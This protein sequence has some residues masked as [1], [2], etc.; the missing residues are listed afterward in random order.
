[1][2]RKRKSKVTRI[3]AMIL[4]I[5]LVTYNIPASAIVQVFAQGEDETAVQQTDVAAGQNQEVEAGQTPE[6]PGNPQTEQPAPAPNVTVNQTG[7]GHVEINGAEYSAPIWISEGTTVPTVITPGEGYEIQ[8]VTI[9]GET[10]EVAD[11]TRFEDDIQI[12]SNT[13]IEVS[14]VL[15]SH[16]IQFNDF[17]NGTVTNDADQQPV[18]ANGEISVQ[19]GTEHSFTATPDTGYHIESIKVGTES[20]DLPTDVKKE[21]NSYQFTVPMVTKNVDVEVKFA[22]NTYT[23]TFIAGENGTVDS[24]ASSGGTVQVDY[25]KQ[26]SF[27]AIPEQNYHVESVKVGKDFIPIPEDVKKETTNFPYEIKNITSNIE[28]RVTFSINTH[29]VT[30]TVKGGNGSVRLDK[31]SVEHDGK[32]TVTIFPD[33]SYRVSEVKVTDA[34]GERSV[35]LESA[36]FISNDNETFTYITDN[37]T[38]DTRIEVSFEAMPAAQPWDKFV[39]IDPNA[40]TLIQKERTDGSNFDNILIYSRDAKLTVKPID[41]YNRVSFSRIFGW[42]QEYTLRESTAISDIRVKTK[43]NFYQKN[44][45]WI[46]LPDRLFLIIDTKNPEVKDIKL[47]DDNNQDGIQVGNKVW[48]K[49]AVTVSGTIDNVK[50]DEKTGIEYSTDI[51][52]VY[53]SKGGYSETDRQ[54]AAFDPKTKEFTF[55]TPDEAYHG[56]YTVWAVDK[57]GN[58]S[59]VEKINI[60]IDKAEPALDGDATNKAVLLSAQSKNSSFAA[61]V[62]NFLTFGTFF[63]EDIEVTVNAVDEASGI[64]SIT[65]QKDKENLPE[66]ESDS[67]RPTGLK[68]VN[69]FTLD[70]GFDGK[71]TAV[72][73][74]N[75]GHQYKVL[76]TNQNSNMMA[77]NGEVMIETEPPTANISVNPAGDVTE[78]VDQ[79]G[80][81]FY[82]GDAKFNVTAQ[83]KKSGIHSVKIEANGKTFKDEK[84]F[85]NK[86]EKETSEL[87]YPFTTG[88]LKDAGIT[89]DNEE[90]SY[91]VSAVVKDNAGNINSSSIDKKIFIDTE[92]PHLT[93]GKEAVNIEYQYDET[94]AKALNFLTFGTF[95]NKQIAIKVNASDNE[96]GSGIKDIYVKATDD[97]QEVQKLK[98]ESDSSNLAT[99]TLDDVHFK[100]TLDVVVTDN[101]NNQAT[102]EVSGANSNILSEK[103]REIMIEQNAP[104]AGITV[105]HDADVSSVTKD[106]KEFYSNDVTFGIHVGDPDS[107]V[108]AVKLHVNGKEIEQDQ[109]YFQNGTEKQTNPAIHD[110]PTASFG[111][112]DVTIN[113]DGSYKLSVEAIDNAGN[114]IDNRENSEDPAKVEKTIYIDKLAPILSDFIF[115]NEDN[116]QNANK[117]TDNVSLTEYGF[118]FKKNTR[119]TV[120]AMDLAQLEDPATGVKTPV[121]AVSGVQSMVIYLKDY[122]NGKYYAVDGN[123]SLKEVAESEKETFQIPT[124]SDVTFEVPASFKGQIFAKAIDAVNN[125]SAF[126]TPDGTVIEDAAK[127]ADKSSI[128]IDPAYKTNYKDNNGL[129][130]YRENMKV[131]VTVADSYSG[132]SEIEW[133]VTAPYDTANNQAGKVKVDDGGNLDPTTDTTGWS[134][135]KMDQNLVTEMTKTL[136][137][138]NNSNDIVVKVKITDRAG[139]VSEKELK[140][141]IDKT[142]P[143][144][145]VTYDNNTPDRDNTDYYKENRTA[146]IVITERNFRPEDVVATITNTDGV[147][148][149]VTGWSTAANAADPDK[150]THTATVTYSA[151]GDY[152]FD[153]S[154]KDNADNA[155]PAVAQQKFTIDKTIPEIKVSYDNNSVSNGNYYKAGRTATISVHEHNFD[156]SRIKVTGTATDGG[157]SIAFPTLSGW[158]ASGDT[159]TATIRYN[160]DGNYSFDIDFTDMAGNVAADYKT[161]AFLVDQTAPALTITGVEDQSA[162]KGDVAPVIAYSDTN[163]NKN[164]VSISLTG[165]NRGKVKPDGSYSDAPNGQVFAFKNFEKAKEND[166]L[167]TLT[168][169]LTD[170]AGN[171][172]TQTILFSVNRFGSVYV[173]D[174]SL[175]KIAGKFVKDER[176][177]IVTETNVD[178]LKPETIKVK[179]TKNGTPTDLVKGKDYTVSETG[180]KGKW[181]QY[182]YEVK[183]D[184][185]SGDGKYSVALYS[186]DKAGNVNENI[187]EA[188]KAEISFGIDKT[189]PVIV[190]IDIE[191]GKQYPVENKTATVSIKDNLVL[192]GAA[193]YLNGKKVDQ[194]V[195]GENFNFEIPSSNSK[196]D[197]KITAVDAAG[198]ELQTNVNDFL[199][200]TNLLVRWYNNTGL[201]AGSIAGISGIGIAATAAVVIRSRRKIAVDE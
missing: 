72:V 28:V 21:T 89:N 121:S 24:L 92:A 29:E 107:G 108:N 113:D 120:K 131:N 8:S 80:N 106:G 47:T 112:K 199:V 150:T 48:F 138:S 182:R 13:V 82:S 94:W 91:Q 201:F 145:N 81:Q 62:I 149:K 186:E 59:Q 155:A 156:P 52:K 25:G 101:V 158:S 38:S 181:S 12:T 65:L 109:Y 58:Q 111:S 16:K 148:P 195:D 147:I 46:S 161:D 37:I 180:G 90:H 56:D 140:F 176:D 162:N 22:V 88:D 146:T 42:S 125:T 132:L 36:N 17:Q 171:Q 179:M 189:A 200:S 27:T 2:F 157:K 110:V 169:T 192:D 68:A 160:A 75:V 55:T 50:K 167:Y 7:Q 10:K 198:N 174:D 114:I 103:N 43:G 51:D 165:A 49:S 1:M 134:S 177:V 44:E 183:K 129:D 45:K 118:Y 136:M 85:P 86:T 96:Y 178:N 30:A 123:G 197:V 69:T 154:Y 170:F 163:F 173:F 184:L 130:L 188:K 139:N 190:P 98:N 9:G 115:T 104:S 164:G 41:P 54:E 31:D 5:L 70:K 14:F 128:N 191:S 76:I 6:S 127:H 66:S 40:G 137:V 4:A 78:Y 117:I 87:S 32:A 144:I 35:S 135:T 100:G 23:V 168:A 84:D 143:S 194:K 95:F 196:Q 18:A 33:E 20:I 74:D 105:K 73:T 133:S 152:T 71:L 159:H 19:H 57:A 116:D 79:E 60:N 26:T 67:F 93:G 193:I 39:S 124:E 63:N 119:V 151:D 153:I 141:S 11:K 187:N 166:D 122:E 64:K 102:Y 53:Y 34:N 61:K 3:L 185:F 83:D 15:Q 175:K 97:K 172:T 126:N 77:E 99:F 142:A